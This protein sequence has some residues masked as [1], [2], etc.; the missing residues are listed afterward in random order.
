MSYLFAG[1]F[2]LALNIDFMGGRERFT[3]L[4]GN[5]NPCGINGINVSKRTFSS[6]FAYR[7]QV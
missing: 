6:D 1:P 2:H 3:G 4:R 7:I 5:T